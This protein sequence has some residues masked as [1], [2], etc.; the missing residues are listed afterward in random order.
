[1]KLLHGLISK[2]IIT[3]FL[4]GVF[5]NSFGQ[6]EI[7]TGTVTDKTGTPVPGVNIRR[8]RFI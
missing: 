7:I 4:I 2:K 6:S 1:M 5:F 8:Y 3:V